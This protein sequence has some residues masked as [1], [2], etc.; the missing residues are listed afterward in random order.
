MFILFVKIRRQAI[1][2]LPQ[3]C[4]DNKD[5]T[6]KIGD[7]LA[8]LLVVE[9]ASELTQVHLSLQTLAKVNIFFEVCR[10]NLN[11][12]YRLFAMGRVFQYAFQNVFG[13]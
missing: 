11:V 12:I 6:A 4:K 1:K 13:F 10:Y 7:I 8:Q 5:N 2:D 9:D 3:L